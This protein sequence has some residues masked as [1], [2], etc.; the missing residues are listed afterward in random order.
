MTTDSIETE[1][2]LMQ[3]LAD[4][5]RE[6]QRLFA[7]WLKQYKGGLGKPKQQQ[8]QQVTQQ[9]AQLEAPQAPQGY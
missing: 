7:D 2:G 9:P 1:K 8:T 4:A 5:D 3:A 6:A